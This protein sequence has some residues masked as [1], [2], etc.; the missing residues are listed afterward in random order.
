MKSVFEFL[1]SVAVDN[2]LKDAPQVFD[3]ALLGPLESIYTVTPPS[4]S[5]VGSVGRTPLPSMSAGS[6]PYLGSPASPWQTHTYPGPISPTS[7]PDFHHPHNYPNSVMMSPPMSSNGSSPRLPGSPL[8][9]VVVQK[10]GSINIE[11]A[12]PVRQSQP[13]PLI[14]LNIPVASPPGA[15]RPSAAVSNVTTMGSKFREELVATLNPT[16]KEQSMRRVAKSPMEA[17]VTPDSDGDT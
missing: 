9:A 12:P 13:P 2:L 6:S 17:F 4:P 5:P 10:M 14:P 1:P 8:P 15:S 7:P 16:L 11:K 3:P